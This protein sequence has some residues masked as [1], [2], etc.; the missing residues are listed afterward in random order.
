MSTGRFLG[1][2]VVGRARK[3]MMV[4]AEAAM[5]DREARLASAVSHFSL[6]S[7]DSAVSALRQREDILL[8]ELFDQADESDR[9]AIRAAPIQILGQS[10]TR[11]VELAITLTEG[12]EQL[13]RYLYIGEN[14]SIDAP[15][16]VKVSPLSWRSET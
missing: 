7:F 6:I 1:P 12:T 14:G 8:G 15:P 9:I 13:K 4:Q 11:Q 10:P 2:V 3:R 5:S 16:N